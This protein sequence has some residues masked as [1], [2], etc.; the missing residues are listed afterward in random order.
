MLILRPKLHELVATDQSRTLKQMEALG[1]AASDAEVARHRTVALTLTSKLTDAQRLLANACLDYVLRL[2]PLV[3]E[4]QLTGFRDDD[5]LELR[6]RIPL[7]IA[8]SAST[9]ADYAV[10]VGD[11]C[12]ADLVV[13]AEGWIA[14]IGSTTARDEHELLSPVGPLAAAALA[15]GECFKTLFRLNYPDSPYSR[16]FV[17]ASGAFSFFDYAYEGSNPPLVP[18]TIDAFL[19]GL[20]GVG[21]AAVR[22]LAELGHD[23]TGMLRLVDAD[24]LSTDNLNRVI[25]ARWK[26]AVA[27]RPK[28]DEAADYL[29]QRTSLQI[30]PHEAHFGEFKRRISVRRNE[31]QYHTV[32]TGLDDD[33]V[34]HQ[35]QRDLPR[36]LI[37]GATG[38]DANLT[39]ERSVV[40]QWGCLGCTRQLDPPTAPADGRCDELPDERAPSI[41]FVSGLAGTLAAAELIKDAAHADAALH[42][43]FDHVFIYPPN[44]EM[45][46]EPSFSSSC[47]I[48]CS[49]PAVQQA[50][51]EKYAPI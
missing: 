23:I 22:T 5:V 16:R 46:S 4:V 48:K 51:R 36:I 28:V 8:D 26:Q 44:A 19:I 33:D 49:S 32:V 25:Y 12:N 21:A 37:D 41:S 30:D 7:E 47:R 43:S 42:G 27:R 14:S 40:G 24:A 45:R 11:A 50:Y 3:G 9:T 38:R 2:D 1:V 20:G 35:V 31:R 15:A 17:P 13:D 29:R 6:D 39:V 34:R 18:L 10:A